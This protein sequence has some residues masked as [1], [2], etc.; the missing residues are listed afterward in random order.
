MCFPT[1]LTRFCRREYK[2]GGF[3]RDKGL[4]KEQKRCSG[5]SHPLESIDKNSF[6]NNGEQLSRACLCYAQRARGPYK[7]RDTEGEAD[8]Q[9]KDRPP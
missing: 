1:V 4:A 2:G 6:S 7:F 5:L 9:L 3:V 8:L